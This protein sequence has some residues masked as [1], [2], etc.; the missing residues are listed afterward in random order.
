[1]TQLKNVLKC[2]GLGII[3]LLC[4]FTVQQLCAAT[5]WMFTNMVNSTGLVAVANFFGGV[6]T[7]LCVLIVIFFMGGIPLAEIYHYKEK[8]GKDE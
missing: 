4:S 8:A 2:L 3:Y 6:L 5:A 1:M 7:A